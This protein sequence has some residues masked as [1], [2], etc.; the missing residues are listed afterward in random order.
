MIAKRFS[1]KSF[2]KLMLA[3]MIG[4]FCC[5]VDKTILYIA[6]SIGIYFISFYL[7]YLSTRT[8][9][10]ITPAYLYFF[11]YTI[12]FYIWA[13]F[14]VARGK[15]YRIGEVVISGPGYDL[16]LAATL[17]ILCFSFG[18]LLSSSFL[19]F[20]PLKELLLF[21]QRKW[22]NDLQG[23]PFNIAISLLVLL[24]LSLAITFFVK[25]GIPILAYTEALGSDSFFGKMGEARINAQRG[26]GYF[27]QGITL[28]L[29]FCTLVLYAKGLLEE[30]RIWKLWAFLIT[31]LTIV[32]MISLTSRGHFAIFLVLLFLLHQLLTKQVNWKK[33]GFFFSLFFVLFVGASIFKMG[34][35]LTIEN[36]PEL[37]IDTFDIFTH[38]LSMGAQQFH[39][40]LQIFP[41]P[42][43][44]LFGVSYIWDIKGILPGPD[45]GFNAWVFTLIY[46]FRM[47]G[48]NVTPL[49]IGEFYANFGWPG[50]IM[51]SFLLGL[52]LQTIYIRFIRSQ[53]KISH[54]VAFVVF[55][56][57][58]A[59]SSMNGLGAIISEP[60]ISM[61]GSYFLLITML[62]FFRR[63]TKEYLCP[64]PC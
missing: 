19:R 14:I 21:R 45:I 27:M 41:E 59:K 63:T 25:Q 37:L 15:S 36:V 43:P 6:L 42:N 39:A 44:F 29:P 55:S 26:A 12:Y 50:I 24:S 32:M 58:I 9:N 48:S 57:Y 51:G 30:Q 4:L 11:F 46:P 18:V 54:L 1:S 28:M 22:L 13:V 53:G 3:V 56:T 20:R 60:I 47:V 7:L 62:G 64:K 34:Y 31:T 23:T 10:L 17:G 8:L 49:S 40:M 2:Y 61:A 33:A 52:L 16:I 5:L 38:R 35:F